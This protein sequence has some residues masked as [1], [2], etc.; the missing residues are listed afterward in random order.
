MTPMP[1]PETNDSPPATR[2]EA[3]ILLHHRLWKLVL[4]S[5]EMGSDLVTINVAQLRKVLEVVPRLHAIDEQAATWSARVVDLEE[6]LADVGALL[7]SRV[8]AGPDSEAAQLAERIRARGIK[9][10]KEPSP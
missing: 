6:L 10:A 9:L 3:E 2:E 7:L 8:F 1:A 5:E 4:D